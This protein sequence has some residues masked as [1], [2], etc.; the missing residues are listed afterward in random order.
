MAS[1]S[2]KALT[3]IKMGSRRGERRYDGSSV[4]SS[5]VVV[6]AVLQL[7]LGTSGVLAVSFYGTSHVYLPLSQASSETSIQL[8]LRTSRSKGLL[9]LAFGDTDYCIIQLKSG[10]IEV[11]LELGGGELQMQS[12]SKEKLNDLKW[13]SVRL[14]VAEGWAEL[15]VD[16]L[17]HQEER[18]IG[19]A[20]TLNIQEG[21]YIGGT[22]GKKIPHLSSVDRFFRGCIE[23]VT[24][25][26]ILVFNATAADGRSTVNDITWDCS[27]EFEAAPDSPISFIKETAFVMYPRWQMST[28]GSFACW[29]KTTSPLGLLMFSS[30]SK[31]KFIASEVVDGKIRVL[32]KRGRRT[33]DFTSDVVIN[34]GNW[35]WV[36]IEI[37]PNK[38][39][40]SIDYEP[41]NKRLQDTTETLDLTGLLHVGGVVHKA[42]SQAFRSDLKSVTH[43]SSGGSFQGCL[44]DVEVNGE[45][46]TLGD[47]RVTHGIEIGCLYQFP[48]TGSPCSWKESC[49]N[50]GLDS[51]T[52]ECV[53]EECLDIIRI[54]EAEKYTTDIPMIETIL[55]IQTEPII[56]SSKSPDDI[57]SLVPVTLEEG[58]RSVVTTTNIHLNLKLRSRGIR[59]SQLLF[60][61]SKRPQH[62]QIE[63]S[64]LRRDDDSSVFTL[65][66]LSGGKIF[67][68]HDG[69]ENFH[70]TVTMKVEVLRKNIA[71]PE[72]LQGGVNFTLGIDITPVNDVP[73]I[74]LADDATLRMIQGAIQPIHSSFLEAIDPDNSPSDLVFTIINQQENVGFFENTN[75]PGKSIVSFTQE[76]IN[77]EFVSYVHTG[78]NTKS[79]IVI[80]IS[81]GQEKSPLYSFRIDAVPLELSIKN[82][83]ELKLNPGSSAVIRPE[84]LHVATNDPED[85]YVVTYRVTDA[86][87]Y[88]KLQRYE[89][90]NWWSD[91]FRFT[92]SEIE[93]GIIRYTATVSNV[94]RSM[95]NDR[96]SLIASSE[97]TSL[98][99]TVPVRIIVTSVN[100][101]NNTGL[102][103][104]IVRQ[105][106]IT[107]HNLSA[108]VLLPLT[109]SPVTFTLVRPPSKGQLIK[110]PEGPIQNGG[111]FTQDDIIAGVIG[112]TLNPEETDAL[113]DTFLFRASVENVQSSVMSFTIAYIPDIRSMIITNTGFV[114]QEGARHTIALD[115]FSVTAGNVTDFMYTIT[116]APSHGELLLVEP[117]TLE[118]NSNEVMNFLNYDLMNGLLFYRHDGSE[119]ERDSF[120][121]TTTATYIDLSG[122]RRTLY[123]EGDVS[124][125]ILLVNDHEP[126]VIVNRLFKVVKNGKTPLTD[127]NLL[128]SDGDTD[129]DDDN[130]EYRRQ[131]SRVG[132]LVYA[133]NESSVYRFTQRQLKDG[134]IVFKQNGAET[135]GRMLFFIF[136]N[137]LS[138]YIS[139]FMD[140]EA[141]DPFVGLQN[142]TGLTLSRGASVVLTSYNLSAET[143]LGIKDKRIEF[144]ITSLPAHGRLLLRGNPVMMFNQESLEAGRIIYEHDNSTAMLDGFNFTIRAKEMTKKGFFN[145]R[146]YLEDHQKPP[147]LNQFKPLVVEQGK[148]VTIDR[149]HLRVTHPNHLPVE[150]VFT[151]TVPPKY[152]ILRLAEES[153]L[154]KR[155]RRQAAEGIESF[156]QLDVNRNRLQY[157]QT[158]S[159]SGSDRFS[160]EVD[161]GF[162]KVTNLTFSVEIA[163]TIVPLRVEDILLP[164]GGSKLITD[165]MIQIA[166]SYYQDQSF[167]FFIKQQPTHSF[168]E[169]MRNTGERLTSFNT[170]DL[171]NEFIYFVHDGSDTLSD[172]FTIIANS[173]ETGK[174]SLLYTI[175]VTVTPVNDQ[176]PE[177]TAND[178]LTTFIGT[179][180]TVTTSILSAMDLDTDDQNLMFVLTTPTNGYVA[181]LPDR[182]RPIL[183]FSQADL[184]EG[185]VIFVHSGSNTGGFRFTVND[186][187]HSTIQQIFSITAK[188]LIITLETNEMLYVEPNSIE[189]ITANHLK[190]VTNEDPIT[191]M[192]RP[193][194]YWLTESP[195]H[196]IIVE[197]IDRD[198]IDED[199][200]SF[201]QI[202]TFTQDQIDRNVVAYKQILDIPVTA[203]RFSFNVHLSR[204][205]NL[206]DETFEITIG[207]KEIISTTQMMTTE[208][209][210]SMVQ[211]TERSS[212]LNL[213]IEVI[214]GGTVSITGDQLNIALLAEDLGA[215][216][217]I[218]EYNILSLPSHG[219]LKK[220]NQDLTV[221]STFLQADLSGDGIQYIHDHSDE[222]EDSFNFTIMAAAPGFAEQV[223]TY[224]GQ[225]V[226][227]IDPINDQPF[228]VVTRGLSMTITQ[229]A[230]KTLSMSD[231]NTVDADNPPEE[232]SY[233][234]ISSPANGKLV[235]TEDPSIEVDFF[236]QK[237]INDGEVTFLHDGGSLSGGFAFMVTDGASKKFKQFSIIVQPAVLYVTVAGNI[238]VIQGDSLGVIAAKT[239]N[240][241]SNN[242]LDK[243]KFNVTIPPEFGVILVDG[244]AQESFSQAELNEARV[245]YSQTDFSSDS[246]Q[247][248][249]L[250]YDEY[251]A[252]GSLNVTVY[253]EP[254]VVVRVMNITTGDTLPLTPEYLNAAELA[255]KVG[256]DLD[257]EI[258]TSPQRGLVLNSTTN[259]AITKFSYSDISN[260]R[261]L[262]V[263][264]YLHLDAEENL[265]DSFV[266]VLSGKEVQPATVTFSVR[267]E[268]QMVPLTTP[269]IPTMAIQTTTRKLNTIRF[270]IKP[271]EDTRGEVTTPIT[272][273]GNTPAAKSFDPSG[274]NPIF[275]IIPVIVI[276]IIVILIMFVLIWRSHRKEKQH[277]S[278]RES[279][280]PEPDIG[281]YPGAQAGPGQTGLMPTIQVMSNL[282]DHHSTGS[283]NGTPPM[284]LNRPLPIPGAFVPQVTVTALGRPPS[285][286]YGDPNS[287]FVTLN[288]NGT[289]HS[290]GSGHGVGN[291]WD[292]CDQ[293]IMDHCGTK[294]PTLKKSQYWV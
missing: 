111:F 204:S 44:R 144:V 151:V 113:N 48:C 166:H 237:Q 132:D 293:E 71:I 38:L 117:S 273:S 254:A 197:I 274:F 86:L 52:C 247:I 131:N 175:N 124:I 206:T 202:S 90:Q 146:I 8:I 138:R 84:V 150:I 159:G 156:T 116:Q 46:Y 103:L 261:V 43:A 92:Q 203:D 288:S 148:A 283:V 171:T 88:G 78:E 260:S 161:N 123:H 99:V 178:G 236:T 228:R 239:F 107:P 177:V 66:D 157:I 122:T 37:S 33:V 188:P 12:L 45:Q 62:G 252:V 147:V 50:T 208:N 140:I 277:V 180:S 19:G 56:T 105:G 192:S 54:T 257:V 135:I 186:G 176:I 134:M 40:I 231:L 112:Y 189:P 129:F 30:G 26:N 31:D 282:P 49:S 142:N 25:N 2:P 222:R 179:D 264:D 42:R 1:S 223:V 209:P 95:W 269:A 174:T 234:L 141:S 200:F 36:K 34:D 216:E 270:G 243:V 61:I 238:S 153:L 81:D 289:V 59:E 127:Q 244:L 106:V 272:P 227:T 212:V 158:K 85:Q 80:R 57:F 278:G 284:T 169:T 185:K 10:F 259:L 91:V 181:K 63:N 184:S 275:V 20:N 96:I 240:V 128:S 217:S 75:N 136:D 294:K 115:E 276:I 267:I 172:S 258:I 93:E 126:E 167:D 281:P 271:V 225:F 149:Y 108:S 155:R 213:G 3:E 28:H 229:G 143:N 47:S 226:I 22:G 286:R 233:E 89:L 23:N 255:Q 39:R 58:G 17:L 287:S 77:Q 139:V 199:F 69:S 215:A 160:F 268:P 98:D 32:M 130:I 221:F 119:T 183:S 7:M 55:P 152:G 120:T 104:D 220:S 15:Y 170:Q 79:R 137:D 253:V 133:Q 241:T 291:R 118:V 214:E 201:A 191:N 68:I 41:E 87:R 210:T 162:V 211:T 145:I 16:G 121:F 102:I 262:F 195:E 173:S 51:F 198:E 60:H 250:A 14:E 114:V 65:L 18:T 193:I 70:D 280:Y 165:E 6:A 292:S 224:S 35:H 97:D 285:P 266:F 76:D 73:H 249:F 279:P 164:E 5:V 110:Q 207:K 4:Y 109:S 256:N 235:L 64:V 67:Y 196:G 74:A 168:L 290:G 53:T 182:G 21:I 83:T 263:A 11:R 13:H 82:N 125:E 72:V 27:E 190:V 251:N 205:Q 94:Q 230:Q 265:N 29:M 24:Y 232:L 154:G 218:F 245:Q 246:D 219:V 194:T 101:V 163:P 100:V 187:V 9:F 248:T 242:N